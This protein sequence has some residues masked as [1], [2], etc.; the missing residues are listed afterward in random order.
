MAAQ[1]TTPTMAPP[2]TDVILAAR[3]VSQVFQ[4]ANGAHV[5]ALRGITLDLRRGEFV[6]I[7]GPSGSGK[8]TLLNILAG[9]DRPSSGEVWLDN[10]P[11]ES[12]ERLGH[13]GLMPQRDLLLPWRDALDNAITG[14]E[15]RGV[16]RR[17][18]RAQALDL[19]QRF[20]LADFVRALPATLSGGMRQRVAL[21]RSAL[22]SGSVLLLDEPFGALD[23]LTRGEL[24]AWLLE[25]WSA[26]GKSI[27]LVTHDVN[28]A[29]VLAD[30]VVILTARPGKVHAVISAPL[31]RPRDAILQA[32]QEFGALRRQL[33]EHLESGL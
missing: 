14:L 20:G 13:V 2:I 18:A 17:Q 5:Q 10:H 21:I 33:L 9:L 24:H 4:S 8:S 27:I 26:L 19:F 28:E 29:L 6:A 15:V 22:A 3:D 1:Q 30:R 16:P 11:T 23:A 7:V 32:G 31:P 25:L 12:R